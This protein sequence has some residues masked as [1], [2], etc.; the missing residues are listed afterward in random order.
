MAEGVEDNRRLVA[1]VYFGV[2][3]GASSEGDGIID[4]VEVLEDVEDNL[5]GVHGGR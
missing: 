1:E 2:E 3:S 4:A 5:W